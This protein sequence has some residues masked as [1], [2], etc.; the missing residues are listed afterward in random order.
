MLSSDKMVILFP[1]GKISSVSR[2]LLSWRH[3]RMEFE[4]RGCT[5][6]HLERQPYRNRPYRWYFECRCLCRRDVYAFLYEAFRPYHS[7]VLDYTRIHRRVDVRLLRRPKCTATMPSFGKMLF[8]CNG[9][10]A[11]HRAKLI[12]EQISCRQNSPRCA[13]CGLSRFIKFI[14]FQRE[15]VV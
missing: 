13:A 3:T 11:T 1:S 9:L 5:S 7:H 15:E 12:W 6:E 2:R 4:R 10:C 14:L 8:T